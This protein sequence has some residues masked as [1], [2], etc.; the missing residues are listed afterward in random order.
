MSKKNKGTL[1]M[2]LLLLAIFTFILYGLFS[3]G[4]FKKKEA[5]QE[6]VVEEITEEVVEETPEIKEEIKKPIVVLDAAFGGELEGYVGIVKEADLNAAIVDKVKNKLSEDERIDVRLSHENHESASVLSKAEII[7]EINPDL[8]I[9]ICAANSDNKSTSG[10]HIYV[11]KPTVE[12]FER[13]LSI[14][15]CVQK[16]FTNDDNPVDIRFMYYVPIGNNTY[17]I[18]YVD[19]E[20][21][22]DKKKNTWLILENTECPAIVVEQMYV[23]S[24]AD[25]DKWTSKEGLERIAESYYKAI[26]NYLGIE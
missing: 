26:L 5:K 20:D 2:I 9:T 8:L 25:I 16:E 22:E 13:S 6:E 11:D 24:Q 3:S 17:Q 14:A 21:K 18:S 10:M 7:N 4:I 12:T 23:T 19:I 15:E 1:S